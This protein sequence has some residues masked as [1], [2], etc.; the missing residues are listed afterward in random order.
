M[1]NERLLEFF[2]YETVGATIPHAAPIPCPEH[3]SHVIKSY[4]VAAGSPAATTS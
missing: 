2:T 1:V 4:T 3:E